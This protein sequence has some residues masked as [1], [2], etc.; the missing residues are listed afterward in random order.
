MITRQTPHTWSSLPTAAKRR[1]RLAT[2]TWPVRRAWWNA[3]AKAS[4]GRCYHG[5]SPLQWISWLRMRLFY[6]AQA[7]GKHAA[8]TTVRAKQT[9]L[10]RMC[11]IMLHSSVPFAMEACRY[12]SKEAVRFVNRLGGVVAASKC[13]YHGAFMCCALYLLL[14]SC[15]RGMLI[16]AARVGCSSRVNRV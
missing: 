7:T 15:R 14:V 8:W 6:A 12:M 5:P 3:S 4:S 13:M 10:T 1:R 9:K 11:Q 16:C 2:G